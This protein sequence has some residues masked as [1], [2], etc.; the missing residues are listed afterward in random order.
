SG[1]AGL[2]TL[3]SQAALGAVQPPNPFSGFVEAGPAVNQIYRR[4][5]AELD[6]LAERTAEVQRAIASACLA[7]LFPGIENRT[8]PATVLTGGG[9][10]TAPPDPLD[11]L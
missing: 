11:Y 10:D 9:I 7:S 5:A 3:L 6:E 8:C 4:Y 2:Q 1:S